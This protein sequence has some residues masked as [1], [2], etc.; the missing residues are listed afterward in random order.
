MVIIFEPW[1][2][3]IEHLEFNKNF[4]KIINKKE[5]ILYIGD[6]SQIEN[7]KKELDEFNYKS[8]KIKKNHIN[9]FGRIKNLINDLKN[10]YF[11]KKIAQKNNV[12]KIYI[13][14]AFPEI[15]FFTKLFLNKYEVSYVMHGYLREV[16]SNFN[17]FKLNSYLKILMKNYNYNKKYIVLGKKIYENLI[18]I[19]P[20]IKENVN[21]LNHPYSI[22]KDQKEKKE[23]SY[24]IKIGTVG[25]GNKEKNNQY[26]FEIEKYLKEKNITNIELYHI[27]KLEESLLVQ[28]TDI[29]IP[30]KDK[31]L[32]KNEFN[33]YVNE[34]DYILY[35]YPKESYSLVASGA[36]FDSI[37]R[38]KNILALKNEYFEEIFSESEKIKCLYD[39][40]DEIKNKIK[41]ISEGIRHEVN[42]EEYDKI[43]QKYLVDNI[44]YN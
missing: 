32:S 18:K 37:F 17:L 36:I 16:E 44:E 8:I 2:K 21:I 10:C 39:S 28:K 9:K 33:S 7:L 6:L 5:E 29:K 24:K 11:C 15:I 26:L 23:K 19:I 35:F 13:T 43:I 22:M 4:F 14:T 3:D 1:A 42:I 40:L 34:L 27:G 20:E 38:Y 31:M 30:A 25:V 41:E 12:K